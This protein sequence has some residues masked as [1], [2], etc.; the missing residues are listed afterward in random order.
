MTPLAEAMASRLAGARRV[1]WTAHDLA[2]LLAAVRPEL[3]VSAERYVLLAEVVAELAAADAVRPTK[4]EVRMG[5]VTLPRSV[6]VVGARRP[7]APENPALRHPWAPV[8]A[9]AASGRRRP[10]AT[11]AALVAISDWV[12]A[13]PSPDV[14]P[15][16][17]R[18]LEVLGDDKALERLL[19]GPLRGR[20]EVVRALAVERVHPPMALGAVGGATGRDVLVVENG[21]TF[22]SALRAA[23]AH[24][25]AG[26]PVRYAHVG[27]GAGEQLATL[28]PSLASLRP[29]GLDYFGDL[30]PEG[31]RFAA[32]GAAACGPAGLP[33]LRPAAVLYELLLARGAAQRKA[34]PAPWPPEGMA[35]LG[36][37]LAAGVRAVTGA[38]GDGGWLAQE[39]VGV[40]V[41]RAD[42]GWCRA[43]GGPP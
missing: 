15:V 27:Y 18:S 43:Y 31:L 37:R 25:A 42:D 16:R 1:R 28:L 2:G 35:W 34:R 6:E 13:H 40:V 11:H 36:D 20:D 39:W 17:E 7:P 22:H 38:A 10:D 26:T 21:T 30:D 3:A 24:A 23:R 5:G 29:A 33:P 19:A 9:W 41:L 32:R 12:G 4:A 14:V 8:M